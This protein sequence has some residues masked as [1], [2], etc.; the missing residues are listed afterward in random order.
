MWID[1]SS[2]KT[3]EKY[4]GWWKSEQLKMAEM[5][6]RYGIDSVRIRTD[7]DYVKPLMNLFKKRA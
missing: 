3:R 1:T 4:S 7:E 5:F 6:K 2:R